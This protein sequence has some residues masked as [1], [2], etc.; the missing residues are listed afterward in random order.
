M[1]GLT[2]AASD[3]LAERQRQIEREG[4]DP[5][6]DDCHDNH[7]IAAAAAYY[8]MPPAT[9]TGYGDTFGEVIAPSDWTMKDYGDWRR[10]L[11]VAAALLLAEIERM[12]RAEGASGVPAG[13]P[14]ER[15][16]RCPQG[17]FSFGQCKAVMLGDPGRCGAS[18]M[19]GPIMRPIS[20]KEIEQIAGRDELTGDAILDFAH[21]L[22]EAAAN[23]PT[24][25]V[26]DGHGETL[27]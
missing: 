15:L 16:Q 3:V 18:V 14:L 20:N 7:E 22:L 13:D 6:H 17:C 5:E 19:V 25:G 1:N 4:C 10:E 11:V 21:R 24:S 8:A 9:E 27:P 2:K 23:P 12:D 26:P